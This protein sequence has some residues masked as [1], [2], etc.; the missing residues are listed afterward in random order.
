[1]SLPF[2]L[3][4]HLAE[5][6][7]ADALCQLPS[8]SSHKSPFNHLCDVF[9]A[10]LCFMMTSISRLLKADMHM[11][12]DYLS[13]VSIDSTQAKEVNLQHLSYKQENMYHAS[14]LL[15]GGVF[16]LEL[17]AHVRFRGFCSLHFS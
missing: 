4:I 1:M 8:G 5:R 7:V 17:H 15:Y 2:L 13:E 10:S 3:S 9:G 11:H 14:R 6:T 16:H 12:P